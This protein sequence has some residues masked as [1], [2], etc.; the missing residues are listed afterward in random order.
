MYCANALEEHAPFVRYKDKDDGQRLKLN[1]SVDQS[2][3][4]GTQITVKKCNH[5]EP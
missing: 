5:K 1:D 4:W 2:W 3:P